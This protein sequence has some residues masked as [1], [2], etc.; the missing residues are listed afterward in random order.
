MDG[1]YHH[2][3]VQRL[4]IQHHVGLD[5]AAA[6][7]A[8]YAGALRDV[9]HAIEPPAAGAVVPQHT[10]V[11]LQHLPAARLLVEAVD[12]LGDDRLQ[13]PLLL[14]L[15]Q[16]PVGRIGLGVRRQ[17]LGAVEVEE[18]LRVPLKKGVAQY[19]LRRIPELL[20]IQPVH[21]AKVGDARL[22]GHTGAAEKH[23]VVGAV[24]QFLQPADVLIHENPSILPTRSRL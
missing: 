24:D 2:V 6:L 9:L 17:H 5:D 4:L 10:A 1:L 16:L 23:D 15:G 13:P 3:L 19:G 18:L 22:R 7:A 20:V 21:T 8:R 11:K 12:V 14:P